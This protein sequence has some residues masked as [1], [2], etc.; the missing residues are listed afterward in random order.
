M[1]NIKEDINVLFDNI[2]SSKLYKDYLEVSKKL[3]KNKDIIDI[4]NE[5]KRY[6]KIATNNKD[7]SVEDKIKKLN[8][9]LE[10]YPLYQSYL[11]IKED[12]EEELFQIKE[13]FEK[14]FKDILKINH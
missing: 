4:I 10:S 14:Y 7:K 12:L 3:E 1:N 13:T 5:I 9:K 8:E 2:E 11:I 6:Q